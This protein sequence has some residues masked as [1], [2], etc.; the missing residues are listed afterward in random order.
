MTTPTDRIARWLAF[1][2]ISRDQL[3]AAVG[4][5]AAKLRD[6]LAV[7]MVPVRHIEDIADLLDASPSWLIMG[8]GEPPCWWPSRG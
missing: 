7:G 4:A 3:A 2:G 5:D 8:R 6:Y 1:C